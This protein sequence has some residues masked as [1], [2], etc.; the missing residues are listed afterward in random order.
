MQQRMRNTRQNPR[1]RR[2]TIPPA[3]AAVAIWALAAAFSMATFAVAA[4]ADGP[5]PREA[6]SCER[7][8]EPAGSEGATT[9]G[10]SSS[11]GQVPSP[12]D[13]TPGLSAADLTERW[14]K[15]YRRVYADLIQQAGIEIYVYDHQSVKLFNGKVTEWWPPAE[16]A[17]RLFHLSSVDWRN[18]PYEDEKTDP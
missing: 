18:L 2:A 13:L 11:T 12:G 10:D 8:A 3:Q 1:G 5:A 14:G 16:N 9:A 4:E 6:T 17:T 15:H 7:M